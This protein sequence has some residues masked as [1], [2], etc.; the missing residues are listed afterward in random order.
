[1][2]ILMLTARDTLKDKLRDFG[3]GA[4]DYLIR[5]PDD[6]LTVIPTR[7]GPK[8]RRRPLGPGGQADRNARAIDSGVCRLASNCRIRGAD[9]PKAGALNG[10]HS[11][12]KLNPEAGNSP[13]TGS[14]RNPET[15]A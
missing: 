12:V 5:Q 14:M 13:A 3:K 1:M 10:C 8:G 11:G 15:G 2:Q 7:S 6:R 9:R 4:D